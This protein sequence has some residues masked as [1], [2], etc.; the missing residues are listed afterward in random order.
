MKK[1]LPTDCG[2][3]CEI[4]DPYIAKL[5]RLLTESISCFSYT[6]VLSGTALVSYNDKVTTLAKN[7]LLIY[8]PGMMIKTLEVSEDFSALCLMGDEA[9]TYEIPY[10]RNI[11]KASYSPCII[12]SDNKLTLSDC[13]ASWLANRM[14]EIIA[15]SNCENHI[16]RDECISSLYALFILDVLNIESR[17]KK[18]MDLNSHT[19]DLFLKFLRLLTENFARHHDIAFYADAL[20]VT[21]IYLSRIVKRFSGQTIKNHVDRMLVMEASYLLTNTDK[22]ISQIAESLNFANPSS[23]CKFFSKQR[24]VSPREYRSSGPVNS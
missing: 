9:T 5:N 13:E 22:T 12:Q 20:A 4:V 21:T 11:I 8:T 19:I 18:N 7:D 6:L 10:A 3:T 15:Y 24:G 2:I 14:N 16:Y 23:F 17:F 1:P